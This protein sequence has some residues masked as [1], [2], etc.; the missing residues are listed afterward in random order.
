MDIIYSGAGGR[1]IDWTTKY[2][3]SEMKKFI[4]GSKYLETRK[5]DYNDIKNYIEGVPKINDTL[6][7]KEFDKINDDAITKIKA[8]K[9]RDMAVP[10]QNVYFLDLVGKYTIQQLGNDRVL[11]EITGETSRVDFEEV[12][13][14]GWRGDMDNY[15]N[16]LWKSGKVSEKTTKDS[17]IKTIVLDETELESVTPNVG[18][19]KTKIEK[20]SSLGFEYIYGDKINR[21]INLREKGLG[22]QGRP[23]KSPTRFGL[24]GKKIIPDDLMQS[25]DKFYQRVKID[26]EGKVSERVPFDL[27]FIFTRSLFFAEE[28]QESLQEKIA[29][30][31]K[32]IKDFNIT[33]T[34]EDK[35][36]TY[37]QK[38]LESLTKSL[39]KAKRYLRMTGDLRKEIKKQMEVYNKTD[40]LLDAA[41]EKIKNAEQLT[42]EELDSISKIGELQRMMGK[43]K[44]KINFKQEY[45][46]FT[47]KKTMPEDEYLLELFDEL[48]DVYDSVVNK[49]IVEWL[50]EYEK[51]GLQLNKEFEKNMPEL[52]KTKLTSKEQKEAFNNPKSFIKNNKDIIR[53]LNDLK[54]VY[55]IKLQVTKKTKKKKGKEEITYTVNT[56]MLTMK[57]ELVRP[58][59][60]KGTGG[61]SEAAPFRQRGATRRAA[62]SKETPS[63]L[64]IEG[65]KSYEVKNDIN[66]FAKRINKKLRQLELVI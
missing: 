15:Y 54:I 43:K 57:E 49:R 52:P 28:M 51:L 23:I 59:V 2:A 30:L 16:E 18:K 14:D 64:A 46:K 65:K 63:P 13:Q 22:K 56:F 32:I 17:E 36:K 44:V 53:A 20:I 40:D 38:K 35:E 4:F 1:S 7:K 39:K 58:I 12:I 24:E 19:P 10:F 5:K 26:D 42:D 45:L 21:D 31:N 60:P 25:Y 11:D 8:T 34:D 62:P 27:P 55:R 29:K 61:G 9:I 47:D 48:T 33:F 3:T 50:E 6:D 37:E 41:R 66:L